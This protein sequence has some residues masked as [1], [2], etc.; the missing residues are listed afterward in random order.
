MRN[1]NKSLL[2][3]ILFSLL[4]SSCLLH[5]S[6]RKRINAGPQTSKATLLAQN[7]ASD[8]TLD[9]SSLQ[10]SGTSQDFNFQDLGQ[11]T[12]SSTDA[13]AT[14]D[15]DSSLSTDTST[16]DASSSQSLMP[17]ASSDA[18]APAQD[19]SVDAQSQEVNEDLG[20]VI[21]ETRRRKRVAKEKTEA[22]PKKKASPQKEEADL[23]LN[24]ENA[25]L[26]SFINYLREKKKINLIPDPQVAGHKISLTIQKPVTLSHAWKL[27]HTI[28][29]MAGYTI[30][31]VG[32]IYKIVP[33]NAKLI[34][35]LPTYINVAPETLPDSDTTIR[36][37]TFLKNVNVNDIKGLLDSMLGSPHQVIP[38][39][40]TNSMV[41]TD[42]SYN[43]KSAMKIIKS[44][45][46]T[47]LQE[48]VIV[49]RL[50]EANA[51]EVADLFKSLANQDQSM[52]P[53]ARFLSRPTDTISNFT[54]TKIIAEER[55]NSL[56]LIGPKSSTEKIESF[57]K[58]HVDTK[59]KGIETPL[60]IYELQN[61]DARQIA[62][63]LKEVTA[64]P[65]SPAGDQASKYG[66]VR[67]NVKYFKPMTI[68]A[69]DEG[70]RLIV[71]TTDLNDWELLKKTIK[72]LD[73]A[74]PQ[75][76]IEALVVT[77]DAA[78]SKEFGAQ[79]RNK[80]SGELG[81]HIDFQSPP[82]NTTIF[83]QDVNN[84]NVSL[85]GNMI[86]GL[87]GGLGK[88]V[89]TFGRES[90]IWGIFDMLR[91]ITNTSVLAQPFLTTSNKYKALITIGE[92][93]RQQSTQTVNT[94]GATAAT[95]FKD[96]EAN[97]EL[98]ITPQINIDGII[99]LKITVKIDSF[100]DSAEVVSTRQLDTFA[101][102]ANGQV[103]ALGGLVK[104]KVTEIVSK[105]PIL[106][107]IPLL[108]WFFKNKTK[109]IT[110]QN[111][112]V[113][114]SPTIIKPRTKPG[115][116]LYTKMKLDLA[117]QVVDES[118]VTSKTPDPVQNW[119]FNPESKRY[120][121]KV[122]DYATARFQPSTVDIK[123]DPY[124]RSSLEFRDKD[125][126]E[127]DF[128]PPQSPEAKEL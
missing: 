18:A 67:S 35:P 118:V 17:D 106:G 104:T 51:K 69:E 76:A 52:H 14:P 63:V 55:T 43:I 97:L 73:V 1:K 126:T 86:T 19:T 30:V 113:F 121:T 90:N 34:E 79:I 23:Y 74:Q 91:R 96:K 120:S 53:L 45:D 101:S 31:K 24:F 66:A 65:Q 95:G 116:N 2:I 77:V 107:D 85:L 20:E 37:L 4:T 5:A 62:E 64:L 12:D 94:D 56:I 87:T 38:F 40:Q 50:Q 32:D 68:K 22:S 124:Y 122:E 70:N 42:L 82:L 47:G 110:K 57:I 117:K 41:I 89:L 111:I 112:L 36:Y 72:S 46:E 99:N 123:N 28:S 54:Q 80:K 103:F 7:D 98:H 15:P 83:K 88:T 29:E 105:T 48:S 6:R 58:E 49:M 100:G 8:P 33:K 13:L 114:C 21:E 26:S 78:D 92:T 115:Y 9:P 93:R 60:H 16:S 59:L 127:K 3:L 61:T 27:L 39:P 102:V 84:N 108:G 44:L 75:V 81:K 10:D 119:F 25:E 128:I 71:S 109:A 125:S 11:S